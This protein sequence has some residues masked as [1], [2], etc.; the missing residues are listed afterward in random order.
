MKNNY[1][2]PCDTKYDNQFDN[3]N[4]LLRYPWVGNNYTSS[5][6]HVLLL[7]DS[8]YATNEDGSHSEEEEIRFKTDKGSTRGTIN[9]V[10]EN[11]CEQGSSW[12]FFNGLLNTF[13]GTTPDSVKSFFGKVAFYNF[14][15]EPMKRSKSKPTPKQQKD[16]WQCLAK[17]TE[18]LNPDYIILFGIRNWYGLES[19]KMGNLTWEKKKNDNCTPATGFLITS[20]GETPLAIIKHAASRGG[21]NPSAWSNYLKE[22][23]PDI[24]SFLMK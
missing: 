16:G 11:F 23:A 13:T 10:I 6:C 19:Q 8:H 1:L 4:L 21:Y 17:V 9:C 20:N 5:K 15:Q 14:I 22:K 18:I 24:M 3:I 12:K 7:G 2:D